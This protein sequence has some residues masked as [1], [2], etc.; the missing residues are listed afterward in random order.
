MADKKQIDFYDGIFHD[1]GEV[2]YQEHENNHSKYEN[3]R[4]LEGVEKIKKTSIQALFGE[5][6][7]ELAQRSGYQSVQHFSPRSLETRPENPIPP[8]GD[9]K[10]AL[11]EQFNK[12]MMARPYIASGGQNE[13]NANEEE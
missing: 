9:E 7:D 12:A 10:R 3:H 11:V 13:Y 4:E 2:P 5:L 8:I 6:N 1:G